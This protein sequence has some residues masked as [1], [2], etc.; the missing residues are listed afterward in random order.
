MKVEITVLVSIRVTQQTLES[1]A[2]SFIVPSAETHV[3]WRF[4]HSEE[5]AS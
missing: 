2:V 5:E 4:R 3:L 1:L